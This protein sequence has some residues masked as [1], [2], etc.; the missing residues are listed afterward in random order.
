MVCLGPCASPVHEKCL[1]KPTKDDDDILC[2]GC[3]AESK[4]E[5][6]PTI[7]VANFR[8]IKLTNIVFRLASELQR[9]NGNIEELKAQVAGLRSPEPPQFPKKSRKKQK[10]T[11]NQSEDIAPPNAPRQSAASSPTAESKQSTEADRGSASVDHSRKASSSSADAYSSAT[12]LSNTGRIQKQRSPRPVLN[13]RTRAAREQSKNKQL[14][15]P[16]SRGTAPESTVIDL[17]RPVEKVKRLFVTHVRP[18][19]SAEQ[20]LEMINAWNTHVKK[21]YR[22]KTQSQKYA[23]FCVMVLEEGF[24]SITEPDRWSKNVRFKEYR[25]HPHSDQIVE[26]A[27]VEPSE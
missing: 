23:S 4:T 9:A 27:P 25:G 7:A 1:I 14:R 12:P 3:K 24:A 16:L 2:P 18:D 8:L 10:S 19:L 13:E 21:V 22:L 6:K 26:V 11:T 20:M 5:V 15:R 17:N